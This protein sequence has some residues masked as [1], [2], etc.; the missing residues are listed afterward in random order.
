MD[1]VKIESRILRG[2]V[3]GLIKHEIKKK[4]GYVVGINL[5]GFHITSSDG[6]IHVHLDIDAS[7][8]RE[9]FEKLLKSRM[10]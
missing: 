7:M 4:T 10:M 9:D 8:G 5:N 2:L 3:S 6:D 1:E